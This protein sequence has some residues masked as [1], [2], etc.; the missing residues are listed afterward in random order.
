MSKL[1]KIIGA[2]LAI[3]GLGGGLAYSQLGGAVPGLAADVATDTQSFTVRKKTITAQM[4]FSTSTDCASRIITTHES[5][6]KLTFD[7]KVA[8]PTPTSGI[9]QPGST[10]VSYDAALYGCGL[11]KVIGCGDNAD[12]IISVI[13]TR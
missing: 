6:I 1:Q 11:V 12:T 8:S 2:V 7:S 4:L 5:A 13:E 9:V 10:T 3:L